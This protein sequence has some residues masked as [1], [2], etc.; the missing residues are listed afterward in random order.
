MP[1]TPHYFIV[2][3]FIP[4]AGLQGILEGAGFI[5]V[6]NPALSKSEE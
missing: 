1:F 5:A 4:A 3:G 6:I 2:R